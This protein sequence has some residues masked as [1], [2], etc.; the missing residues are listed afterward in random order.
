M[1]DKLGAAALLLSA[2]VSLALFKDSFP[3]I[4]TLKA[5]PKAADQMAIPSLMDLDRQLA[6][7][8]AKTGPLAASPASATMLRSSDAAECYIGRNLLARKTYEREASLRGL[9]DYDTSSLQT[10]M[11]ERL[12]KA[13]HEL[14]QVGVDHDDLALRGRVPDTKCVDVVKSAFAF[15]INA[16]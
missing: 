11:N 8:V 10:K 4:G 1:N 3:S 6:R 15:V 5:V 13:M 9:N 12:L 16:D 14:T 7:D 2:A